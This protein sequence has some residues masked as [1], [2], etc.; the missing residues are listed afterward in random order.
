MSSE[1]ARNLSND[2]QD[3]RLLSLHTWPDAPAL[4]DSGGHGPYV[5]MQKAIDP[6]DLRAT[7]EDFI[8]GKSGRWL[9]LYLF[10]KLPQ[11]LRREQFIFAAAAEVIEVLQGLTGK[12]TIERGQPAPAGSGDAQPSDAGTDPLNKA[13][14]E[15]LQRD[16][17][18]QA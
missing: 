18:T 3:V 2:F 1:N 5:V 17:D 9:P 7:V 16:P 11:D 6:E 4:R 14:Q 12:P 8:L 10:Q 15:A 13:I